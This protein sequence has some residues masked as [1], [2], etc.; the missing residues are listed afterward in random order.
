MLHALY[1]LVPVKL[2]EGRLWHNMILV[3]C[4][5][6]AQGYRTCINF[7]QLINVYSPV[8]QNETRTE[9]GTAR[10]YHFI[11]VT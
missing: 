8:L 5:R 1:C 3:S 2:E 11:H 10:L 7:L 9:S 4:V 6:S